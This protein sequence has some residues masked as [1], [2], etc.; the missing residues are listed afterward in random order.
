M[1][2]VIVA[3]PVKEG[4]VRDKMVQPNTVLFVENING[5][6]PSLAVRYVTTVRPTVRTVPLSR[7]GER[8]PAHTSIDM[9]TGRGG[10]LSSFIMTLYQLGH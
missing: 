7:R 6:P 8:G 10:K 5:F 4:F 1:E 3:D 9:V 2:N